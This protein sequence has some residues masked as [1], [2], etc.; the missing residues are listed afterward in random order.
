M[1]RV[2]IFLPEEQDRRLEELA[3]RRRESKAKVVRRALD[4]LFRSESTEREPLLELIGQTE[5]AG[6]R[7]VSTKHDRVLMAA[8]RRR[9]RRG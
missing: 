7:D 2:Q 6:R 3:A 4:L 8:E 9:N 1:T 5:R